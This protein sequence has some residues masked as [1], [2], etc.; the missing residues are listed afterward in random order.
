MFEERESRPAYVR[1][2]RQAVEDKAA[3]R[4]QSK[5][6]AKD[7]DYVKITPPYTRD[8]MTMKVESWLE[9]IRGQAARGDIKPEWYDGYVKSYESWKKGEEM[10]LVGTAIRGWGVIGPAQQQTL[11][12]MNIMTVEDLAAVNEEGLRRIGMGAGELISKAKA[13]LAQLND[14]GP[15]TMQ[16]AALESKIA[17]QDGIIAGLEERNKMLLEQVALYERSSAVA[18]QFQHL[19][20]VETYQISAEELFGDDPEANTTQTPLPARRGRPPKQAAA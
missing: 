8:V 7:V 10:P 9:L 3:S 20:P 11:I 4:A 1:F 13:W 5:Y 6:V 19:E 16:V 2:E 17:V 15:L 12:G 18:A 14:K